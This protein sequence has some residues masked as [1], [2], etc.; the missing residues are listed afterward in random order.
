MSALFCSPS[1]M[2]EE[3]GGWARAILSRNARGERVP[4]PSPSRSREGGK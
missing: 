1:R 4:T 2:R 3:V